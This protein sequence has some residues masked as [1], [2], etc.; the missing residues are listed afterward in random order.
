M[1]EVPYDVSADGERFVVSTAVASGS[2]SLTI[3]FNWPQLI[4]KQGTR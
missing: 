4:A 1:G 2:A 3:V